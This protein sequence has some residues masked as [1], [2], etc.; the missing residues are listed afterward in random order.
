MQA[1]PYNMQTGPPNMQFGPPNMQ[2]GPPTT[3]NQFVPLSSQM[4]QSAPATAIQHKPGAM[5]ETS[6]PQA[7]AEEKVGTPR[8]EM[9]R[10][11][12]QFKI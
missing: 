12:G 7:T 4:Q 11:K 10:D 8:E 1:G 6:G 5:T 3:G 2:A 9:S